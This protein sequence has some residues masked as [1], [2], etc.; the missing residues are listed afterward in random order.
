MR[1]RGTTFAGIFLVCLAHC[2]AMFAQWTVHS[3]GELAQS[4]C[5]WLLCP[6]LTMCV[7]LLLLLLLLTLRR[8]HHPA[9]T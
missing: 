8:C 3:R 9:G 5:V 7:L 4:M 6:L 2:W 1:V